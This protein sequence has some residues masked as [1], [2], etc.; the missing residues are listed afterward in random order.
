MG[1]FLAG[2]VLGLLLPPA[3]YISLALAGRLSVVADAEPPGWEKVL[4][5]HALQKSIVRQAPEQKNP[6]PPTE[7]N[8]LAGMKTFVD[9]CAGCHG[10]AAKKSRWGA[11]E[12]YPRAPQFGFAPPDLTESQ[13]F[14]VIK[15][16]IRYSGMGGNGGEGGYP[17]E[18]IWKMASFLSSLKS[19][20][21]KV[22]EEWQKAA[23]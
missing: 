12:F 7:E 13:I 5:S 4:A 16:G 6:V 20:P 11:E 17:D 18:K 8:L 1:K 3:V 9:G 14:W 2:L 23:M 19:L 22:A 10:T 21:P 15:K